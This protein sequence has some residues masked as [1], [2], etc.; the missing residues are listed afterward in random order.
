MKKEKNE[1]LRFRENRVR[2]FIN[3]IANNR[4]ENVL[5]AKMNKKRRAK[6][7]FKK[8]D[9]ICFVENCTWRTGVSTGDQF[10]NSIF[11]KAKHLTKRFYSRF[12]TEKNLS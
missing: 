10:S 6:I 11:S 8:I 2:K 1:I 12:R 9:R 5:R 7:F 3:L 4:H